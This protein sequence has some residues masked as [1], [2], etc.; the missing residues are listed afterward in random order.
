MDIL[1]IYCYTCLNLVQ[2]KHGIIIA[3]VVPYHA[4][5]HGIVHSTIA[6]F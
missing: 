1:W 5:V 2:S 6:V 4:I 3:V